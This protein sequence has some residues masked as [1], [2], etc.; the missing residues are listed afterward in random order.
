VIVYA[1]RWLE[2]GAMLGEMSPM[3]DGDVVY[4]R[5]SGPEAD[6]TVIAQYPGRAVYYLSKG[7]LYATAPPP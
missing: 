7:S 3:R 2:Y 4:A 5:G 1:D 6:S